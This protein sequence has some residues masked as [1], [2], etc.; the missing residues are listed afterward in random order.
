MGMIYQ[1]K[2]KKP[3]GSIYVEPVLWIKYYANGKVHRESTGSDEMS[4]AEKM[5]RDREK[6]KDDGEDFTPKSIK[7]KVGAL[8]DNL[9]IW[10][11]NNKKKSAEIVEFR[12]DKHLRPYFG[13]RKASKITAADIEKYKSDRMSGEEKPSVCTVNGELRILRTAYHKGIE[14]KLYTGSIPKFNFFDESANIRQGIVKPKP[15]LTLISKLPD[16][17][18]GL[19]CFA[20]LCGW[21]LSEILNL[22]WFQVDFDF[23][24]D[25]EKVIE[26]SL[27][28]G[29]TKNQKPRKIYA[30]YSDEIA[31]VLLEQK[32]KDDELR[33][34]G[35]I[36]PYVFNRNGKQIL[37]FRSAWETATSKAGLASLNF[38]D[39]RRSALTNMMKQPNF[40]ETLTMKFSG[41]CDPKVFKRYL[42][43]K[44]EDILQGSGSLSTGLGHQLGHQSG[45]SKTGTE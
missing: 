9:I 30:R 26:I 44:P 28:A 39:L 5:L 13:D 4:H 34:R 7:A 19:V 32:R 36:C 45:T 22:Q 12:I 3:D 33:A 8:L 37:D 14:Q 43:V 18:V 6:R 11:K 21:R 41:H 31:Q 10:H 27:L 29:S 23:G 2:R 17:L 1:K 25:G 40:N 16:Y 15:F 24:L 35:I 42:I 20:Y 38:H